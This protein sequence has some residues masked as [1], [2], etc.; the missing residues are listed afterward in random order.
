MISSTSSEGKM[1]LALKITDLQD[2][3]FASPT[4][5]YTKLC[6]GCD[7]D[8]PRHVDRSK[9]TRCRGTGREPLSFAS[10]FAEIS[11]SKREA[12][13]AAKEKTRKTKQRHPVDD[14]EDS[15]DLD[16]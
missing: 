16:Y 3:S 12:G 4:T 10:T 2:D 7:P 5:P 1:G 6:S 11:E 13:Q 8:V 14:D 9:C 15:L